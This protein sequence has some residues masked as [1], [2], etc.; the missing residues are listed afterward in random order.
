MLLPNKHSDP[1]KT[2][3]FVAA[4]IIKKMSSK[5]VMKYTDL[6]NHC[7]STAPGSEFLFN[8]ALSLLFLLGRIQ[9][10]AKNDIIEYRQKNE[11]I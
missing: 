9:Y 11:N 4:T 2:V 8:Q 7:K 3:I 5:R 10:R 6:I 1:D